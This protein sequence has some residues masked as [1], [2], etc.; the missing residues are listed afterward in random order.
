MSSF[1]QVWRHM[2]IDAAA[3]YID[4]HGDALLCACLHVLRDGAAPPPDVVAVAGRGQREDG[5]FAPFWAPGASSLDATCYRLQQLAGLGDAIEHIADRARR[6]LVD[7]QRA[8]GFFTEDEALAGQAPPWA[9]P[10]DLGATLYLSANC[11]GQLVG[12]AN[13]A[14]AAAARAIAAHVAAD[15]RLSTFVHGHWLAVSVLAAAG[16]DDLA[17]RVLQTIEGQVDQLGPTALAWLAT[18]V[19]DS[20]A[21]GR[22]RA[23]LAALQQPDGRWA[24]EDGPQSDAGTTL[25]VLRTVR[26]RWGR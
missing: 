17:A 25:A 6:F 16:M 15:G 11:A 5:G 18:T 19:P 4:Q 24:S 8:D 7:R 23:R 14:V 3:A 10:G 20:S 21:A 9:R 13:G 26:D 2:N 1:G 22:A 12:H